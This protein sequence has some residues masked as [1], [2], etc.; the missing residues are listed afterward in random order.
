MSGTGLEVFDTTISKTNAWLNEIML[1]LDTDDK[2]QAY[3]ALSAVL[4]VLRDRLPPDEVAAFGAQLPMLIRGLYYE[5][6]KPRAKPERLHRL[7]EFTLRVQDALGRNP[8]DADNATRVVFGV[9]TRHLSA[10]E[11]AHIRAILP[12]QLKELWA[13]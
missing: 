4:H 9:L 11:P 10:G 3:A 2:H 1:G 13:S 6:W 7:E 12:G 8:I 5:G